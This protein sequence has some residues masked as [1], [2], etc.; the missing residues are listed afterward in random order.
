MSQM[1]SKLDSMPGMTG[2][3]PNAV[4]ALI[5]SILSALLCC[6]PAG[7]VGIVFSALAMGKANGSDV[8]GARQNIKTA[9][10]CVLA[11]VGLFV[12]GFVL[13]VLFVV[14]I[15]GAAFFGGRQGP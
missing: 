3:K 1:M 8:A 15:G 2:E 7:I 13:Y 11:G 12:I 5:A 6:L 10:I 9:W 14:I 4:P